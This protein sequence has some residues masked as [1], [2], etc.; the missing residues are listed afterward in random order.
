[1]IS[2]FFSDRMAFLLSAAGLVLLMVTTSSCGDTRH[3][4]YMQGKFDTARLSKIDL[5][6][7]KYK[8]SIPTQNTWSAG[9][10]W[11]RISG[12]NTRKVYHGKI[13]IQ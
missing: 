1:M 8:L 12:N 4:T 13:V 10:Y 6:E 5:K 11:L 9:V 3:L 7:L 2:K